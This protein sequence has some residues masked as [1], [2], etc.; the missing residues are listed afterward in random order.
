[1]TGQKPLQRFHSGHPVAYQQVLLA[2]SRECM[3]TV[4]CTPATEVFIQIEGRLA[5]P[6]LD[7][8]QPFGDNVQARC[9]EPNRCA[10]KRDHDPSL[11]CI[12]RLIQAPPPSYC[13]SSPK[14]DTVAVSLFPPGFAPQLFARCILHPIY[15]REVLISLDLCY[16]FHDGMGGGCFA[17]GLGIIFGVRRER[18][19]GWTTAK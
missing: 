8:G 1:L 17:S 19:G 5:V 15:R 18:A 16:L 13:A 10:H 3:R 9:D 14:P 2:R 6:Q 7:V 12:V 11:S 4:L